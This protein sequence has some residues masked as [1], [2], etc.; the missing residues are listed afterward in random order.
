MTLLDDVMGTLLTVNKEEKPSG[1]PLTAS[2]VTAK[3]AVEF[4]APV[5]TPQTV[6]VTARV[7]K[8]EGRRFFM[9]G[10]VVDAEGKVLAKGEAV[11]V[12]VQR[13]R[14]SWKQKKTGK[15]RL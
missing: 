4:K 13:D 8:M 10:E 7:E 14:G 15:E 6:M 3:L 2:T 12:R 9:V 11:W 1:K 5:R